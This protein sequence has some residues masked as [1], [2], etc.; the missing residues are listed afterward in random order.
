MRL[1][2]AR[3]FLISTMVKTTREEISSK[4]PN[5]TLITNAVQ[6]DQ[7]TDLTM[8]I[9]E[10]FYHIHMVDKKME[11]LIADRQ[12]NPPHRNL[13]VRLMEMKDMALIS[14]QK[15]KLRRLIAASLSG[16]NG[17]TVALIVT[18]EPGLV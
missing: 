12:P 14:N 1:E 13:S 4:H 3:K 15:Q 9:Q 11:A 8:T 7:Q 10:M 18:E 17:Q 2:R 6:G 5:L 16:A